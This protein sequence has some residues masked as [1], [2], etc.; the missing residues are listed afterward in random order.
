MIENQKQML[1]Q[2][3]GYTPDP[4]VY[5]LVIKKN[6]SDNCPFI[7]QHDDLPVQNE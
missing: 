1:C 3:E 6:A 5:P 7:D 2:N 4:M